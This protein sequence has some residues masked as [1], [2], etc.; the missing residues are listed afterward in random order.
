MPHPTL[1]ALPLHVDLT[2]S[3]HLE[4]VDRAVDELMTDGVSDDELEA[5]ELQLLGADGPCPIFPLL[6]LKV[7][8]S[9]AIISR[10][11]GDV[12][13]SVVLAM[14]KEHNRIRRNQEHPHGEDFLRRKVSQLEALLADRSNFR[15]KLVLVDDGCPEGSGRIAEEIIESEGLGDKV[16]VRFLEEALRKGDMP[17]RGL[18]ATDESQKGGAI[19]HGLWHSV[20]EEGKGDR[21]VV[22]TDADLS[23]HLGQVGALIEPILDG[24][25]DVAIGSRREPTSVVVKQGTR[26]DR[27]KLFIYLWKRMVPVLGDVIDTQCGFKAFRRETLQDIMDDLLEYR[28]AFDIELLMRAALR[29]GSAI[30]KVPVAW[31]D[32]EEASTT[33]DLQPYLPMLKSIAGMY[34][35]Y[36][37]PDP[38]QEEF[39][40]FI[41]SLDEAGF[42]RLISRIP[43]T[44]AEREPYELADFDGV[45]VDDLRSA[46]P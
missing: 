2:S 4:Q 35:A 1:D 43:S 34:R 32:S 26:N 22:Y 8:R 21:I 15:W 45:T 46:I 44:I 19:I 25:S 30:K 12:D 10:H 3:E 31:I 27:G 9:R 42:A 24:Q 38:A 18:S 17:T 14:Y 33:T 29:S 11:E 23:T 20:R 7:A 5:L 37:P 28:F 41:E 13:L 40:T 39:A 36:L 16:E 6:V